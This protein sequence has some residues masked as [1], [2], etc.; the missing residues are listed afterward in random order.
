MNVPSGL[1]RQSQGSLSTPPGLSDAG[2][3]G[4]SAA[5]VKSLLWAGALLAFPADEQ[6]LAHITV[7]EDPALIAVPG[8]SRYRS[9]SLSLSLKTVL[10]DPTLID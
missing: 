4:P 7:I 1:R 10:Q 8:A 6:P 2:W 9:L 5:M 3:D